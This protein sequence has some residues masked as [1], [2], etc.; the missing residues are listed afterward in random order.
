VRVDQLLHDDR[1]VD[2][3]VVE[4]V[5]QAV[6]HGPLGEQRGPTPA[7]VLEDRGRA[8]DVQERVVLTSEGG[9][10]RVL[11]RRARSD[12]VGDLVA[13][14]GE[15]EGDRRRDVVGDGGPFEGP[16]DLRAEPANGFPVAG[17]EARQPIEQAGDRRRLRH[18]LPEGARRHAEARRHPDAFDLRERCQ[19]GALAAGDRGL[20]P[21]D[22]VEAHHVAIRRRMLVHTHRAAPFVVCGERVW[23]RPG[24]LKQAPWW[25]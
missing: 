1:H 18:H 13:A 6:G 23:S 2:L 11:R 25:P 19:M 3:P 14:A 17:V 24:G 22:L 16:A 12:G 5:A 20:R 15:R 7:D 10:R 21:V 4:A 8:R 9:R